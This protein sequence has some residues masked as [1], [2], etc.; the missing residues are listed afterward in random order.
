MTTVN[1]KVANLRRIGYDSLEHWMESEDNVYVGRNGR[2][3]IHENGNKRAYVYG[4]SKWCNPHKV[5]KDG[6]LETV[7][8]Q[9]RH[10]LNELLKDEVNREEFLK[11][12]GKNLGCWCKPNKCH[13]DIILEVLNEM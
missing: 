4:S 8:E 6:S 10:H 2:V 9:Y 13:A 1:V 7:L 12:K 3:F 5:D 11:L